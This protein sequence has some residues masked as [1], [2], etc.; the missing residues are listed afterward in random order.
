MIDDIISKTARKHISD[1]NIILEDWQKAWLIYHSDLDWSSQLDRLRELEDNTD[2]KLLSE[3]IIFY[4]I[5]EYEKY[6]KFFES[7]DGVVYILS[8][9]FPGDVEMTRQG[10][11]DSRIDLDIVNKIFPY[12]HSIEKAC[13]IRD[14][15]EFVLDDI[16]FLENETL[17]T[18]QYDNCGRITDIY[19]R[20]TDIEEWSDNHDGDM[21]YDRYFQ[22]NHPF[23]LGD[24]VKRMD[25]DNSDDILIIATRSDGV[26]GIDAS[27]SGILVNAF[28]RNTGFMWNSDE[29]QNPYIFDYC[30]IPT[31]T[32]DLAEKIALEWSDVL[33]G[34][35]GSLQFIQ[36]GSQFLRESYEDRHKSSYITGFLLRDSRFI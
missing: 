15:D 2:D 34:N 33:K 13:L 18:V 3:Q 17:G 19:A 20:G 25:A 30:E 12:P 36:D 14:K 32:D 6:D 4:V 9:L 5:E 7:E 24:I 1:N 31:D 21:F 27:D 23:K 26:P 16:G 29:P 28:D 22:F 10:V 11:F 35:G 8:V